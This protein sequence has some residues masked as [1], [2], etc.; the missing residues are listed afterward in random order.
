[1][2][3]DLFLFASVASTP[4]AIPAGELEA[5]VRLGEIVPVARSQPHVRGLAALRSRVLTVIDIRARIVGELT[6]LAREP[7]AIVAMIEGHGF[8]L[9]VDSVQ[10]IGHPVGSVQRTH[11]RVEPSWQPFVRGMLVHEQRT[12][13]ILS[14]HDL[15]LGTAPAGLAA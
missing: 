12:H 8:G 14:V 6:E 7:L 4:I 10:D 1:M 9:I 2:I 13:V 5:V 3:G 15:A 11:G